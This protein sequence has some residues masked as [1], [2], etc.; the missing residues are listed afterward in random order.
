[1][2]GRFVMDQAIF[3]NMHLISNYFWIPSTV[4][5]PPRV[6]QGGIIIPSARGPLLNGVEGNPERESKF[7]T[8]CL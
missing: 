2:E 8:N 3:K 7:L 6:I 5:G 4:Y 1:M